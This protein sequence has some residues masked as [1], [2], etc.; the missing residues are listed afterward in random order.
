[1][2]LLILSNCAA[3]G[4]HL[5]AGTVYAGPAD[6]GAAHA[7]LLLRMGRARV[8]P[9]PAEQAGTADAPPDAQAAAAP[10]ARKRRSA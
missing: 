10:R 7:E 5:A 2:R 9:Q 1:M 6:L 3:G 4:A 8:L